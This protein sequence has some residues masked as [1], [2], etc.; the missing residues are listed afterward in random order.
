MPYP[1]AL[2]AL[3]VS[4]AGTGANI[5]GQNQ[6]AGARDAA[7]RAE[8]NRQAGYRKEAQ[9]IA[10]QSISESGA[11]NAQQDINANTADRAARFNAIVSQGQ[12]PLT[13]NT[14]NRSVVTTAA[15]G[16]MTP[17]GTA[18]AQ[19]WNKIL[20][21]AQARLGG[22]SD[23][24]LSRNIA[25]QRAG[26]KLDTIGTDA[27]NSANILQADLMD[28]N[29]AGDGLSMAGTVLGALGSLG[30]MYAA[31]MPAAGAANVAGTAGVDYTPRLLEWGSLPA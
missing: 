9:A 26:Q 20:G 17:Q 18:S 28:A 23:W 24:G 4:A 8:M 29:H 16:R 11:A 14:V 22:Y 3:A 6:A 19:A 13:G 2:A 21:G 1:L 15:G 31:T 27:R 7:T 25:A 30:G 12:A 10:E 5:A